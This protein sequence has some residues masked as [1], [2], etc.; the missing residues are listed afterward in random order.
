[1]KE[2]IVN[3]GYPLSGLVELSGSK[4]AALPVI[5]ATIATKGKSVINGVPDITDVDVALKIIAGFGA[6]VERI[7]DS[8][9]ID[10]EELHYTVPNMELT[11]RI[12]ASSYLIGACLSRFGIFHLS[13]FGGCNFCNR[14]IDIH[15]A[16]ASALGASLDNGVLYAK[17]MRGSNIVLS[18]PS[19]GATINAL[20]MAS[21]AE[22]AT[23]IK[24]CAKEP[25]VK[26]LAEFLRSSGG[27][28]EDI[29]DGFAVFGRELHGARITIIPDMIEAGTY[30]LL[31]PLTGGTVSVKAKDLELESFLAVLDDSGIRVF[32]RDG[33]I[34]V[35][36]EPRKAL[37]VKTAPHPAYPTDLQP[38]IAP[39]MARYSGG[40]ITE[41]VWQDRFSYLRSLK[42]FG[43]R[44]DLCG[45]EARIFSSRISCATT[46]ATDLRGGAAAL[47][48]ALCA[49]GVS[50]IKNADLI[51]RGYSD[52]ESKLGAIGAE[53]RVMDG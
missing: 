14:P 38:Q 5:F 47:M 22:G 20:I 39:L 11:S 42:P 53:I 29:E 1:M 23:V 4:N 37:R 10:T 26:M 16:A 2:I 46:E 6:C 7:G 33:I 51:F 34:S 18:K 8:V 48:L 45:S 27:V 52:I 43:V 25:H 13:E 12:R 30:L 28:I 41:N 35:S 40:V 44:F 50:K 15:L 24:G 36:G 49:E 32:E 9:V 17:K 3:G 31:G 19:V 21:C